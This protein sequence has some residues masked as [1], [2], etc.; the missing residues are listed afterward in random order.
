MPMCLAGLL[1]ILGFY[2]FTKRIA[3]IFAASLAVVL[4]ASDPS[5]L[6]ADTFDWGPVAL[7]HLLLVAG[8]C[9]VVRGNLRAGFFVFGLGLWDKAVFVWP[10]AGL[11]AGAVAAYLPEIHRAARNK[12]R[13]AE[14]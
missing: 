13:I 12:R 7:Q 4:L 10:L 5:F 1:T 11:A 6:L 9:L 14:A 2:Y 8:C 3:G